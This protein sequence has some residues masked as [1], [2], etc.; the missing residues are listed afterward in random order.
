MTNDQYAAGQILDNYPDG[1][2][3]VW[4]ANGMTSSCWPQDLF[5]L[6]DYDSDD[7]EIWD[8]NGR[9][10]DN[11]EDDE[12]SSDSSWETEAEEELNDG[13]AAQRYL[14]I[15]K[16]IE[17]IQKTLVC[18]RETIVASTP[19]VVPAEGETPKPNLS[20]NVDRRGITKKLLLIYKDCQ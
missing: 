2:V 1:Q 14:T 10:S 3:R 15:G 18:I 7:G 13:D 9:D 8:D 11:D 19:V 16:L 12:F 5:R 4:W 17:Q 20:L 6:G